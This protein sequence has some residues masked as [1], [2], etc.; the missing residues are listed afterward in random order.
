VSVLQHSLAIMATLIA[1]VATIN[2]ARR[3]MEKANHELKKSNT[4]TEA[5][6]AGA[7]AI[8][9][10]HLDRW[11]ALGD[12]IRRRDIAEVEFDAR[13]FRR[14]STLWAVI[15]VGA[16]LALAAEVVNGFIG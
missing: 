3:A 14:V 4:A 13:H 6:E 16:V 9:F 11:K 2:Q 1:L 12:A 7:G 5:A 8:T 15:T 10:Q